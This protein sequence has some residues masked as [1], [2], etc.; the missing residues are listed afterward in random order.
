MIWAFSHIFSRLVCCS[1]L[2]YYSVWRY[3][4]EA[5][6]PWKGEEKKSDDSTHHKSEGSFRGVKFIK[7]TPSRLLVQ[8]CVFKLSFLG[9]GI[10][11]MCVARS[12]YG[13]WRA[14]FLERLE[15]ASWFC[16]FN[17]SQQNKRQSNDLFTHHQVVNYELST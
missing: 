8:K 6:T 11:Y 10:P 14:S 7:H 5:W 3:N 15:C 9:S 12:C 13:L 4:N 17:A 2:F 1:V 16:W